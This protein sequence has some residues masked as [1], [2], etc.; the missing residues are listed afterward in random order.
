M[1]YNIIVICRQT[2]DGLRYPRVL[3][4][5]NC[6]NHV[7]AFLFSGRL[8]ACRKCIDFTMMDTVLA[9]TCIMKL[10]I[11]TLGEPGRAE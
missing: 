1:V 4:F 7:P 8:D 5:I 3:H 10:A 6:R 2:A 9:R 11:D